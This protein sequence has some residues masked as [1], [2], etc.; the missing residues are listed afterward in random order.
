MPELL[1]IDT[2]PAFCALA[3]T[4]F[5]AGARVE[6]GPLTGAACDCV[7]HPGNPY[8]HLVSQLD[9]V[10]LEH[11]GPTYLNALHAKLHEQGAQPV[12][13]TCLV[14]TGHPR[15]RWVLHA[16]CYPQ[17]RPAVAYTSLRSALQTILAHNATCEPEDR[18][19]TLAC[20]GLG[21]YRGCS[22]QEEAASQMAAALSEVARAAAGSGAAA[23]SASAA[24][25]APPPATLPSAI[26]ATYAPAASPAPSKAEMLDLQFDLARSPL[27]DGLLVPLSLPA[28]LSVPASSSVRQLAA[29]AAAL[30]REAGREVSVSLV[31]NPARQLVA[32][33]HERVDAC[34]DAGDVVHLVVER[35][36]PPTAGVAARAR[37]SAAATLPSPSD[38]IPIT[39]LTGFLGAGGPCGA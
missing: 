34:F 35:V 36:A 9:R 39:I 30:M 32:P 3:A 21:T 7:V 25:S 10:I 23:G 27:P 29:A 1:V 24:A 20:P 13:A 4:A 33:L 28:P 2:D 22:H 8:G 16:V 26:E 37:S 14:R 31:L 15:Q 38:R 12:G 5:G 6:H 18:I 11:F 17:N 19:R